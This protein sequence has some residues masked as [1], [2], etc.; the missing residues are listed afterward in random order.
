MA[1]LAYLG[2]LLIFKKMNPKISLFRIFLILT[3][4]AFSAFLG[5][6]LFYL[7]FE[8]QAQGNLWKNIFQGPRGLTFYGALGAGLPIFYLSCLFFL[9][10]ICRKRI[11]D[12]AA[13]ATAMAWVFMKVGCL[14]VGC[15]WGKVNLGFWSIVFDH[16]GS[17]M[18]FL[19]VPVYPVQVIDIAWGILAFAFLGNMFTRR[20]IA[21]GKLLPTYLAIYAICRFLTEFLRGDSG[22]GENI[23][24]IF[25]T[26]QLISIAMLLALAICFFAGSFPKKYL[27]SASAIFILFSFSACHYPQPPSSAQFLWVDH[28]HVDF[29]VYASRSTKPRKNAIFIAADENIQIYFAGDFAKQNGRAKNIEELAWWASA[30]LMSE[31][32]AKILR[33][34]PEKLRYASLAESLEYME[35]LGEPFD[36][37][38][39][40]H[41][42]PNH[43]SAGGR[44]YFL[45]HREL[46]A[47]KGKFSYLNLV[48]LQSCFGTT[49]ARDFLV[50]GA[51]QVIA[52]DGFNRSFFYFYF[53]LERI[54]IDEPIVAFEW[55]SARINYLI[56]GN[57]LANELLSTMGVTTEDY[58]KEI[59]NPQWF[60]R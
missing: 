16:P 23:L 37:Y 20:S 34:P 60:T 52:F 35:S 7:V 49:L 40:T 42:L 32:Y 28:S 31:N 38:L 54:R 51:N 25:S 44:G 43:L 9:N 26:S 58:L 6:R 5:A 48:F 56:R 24:W 41:G 50:A 29:E 15:C 46:L 21:S 55:V 53:F 30:P 3:I 11:F 22:R 33:I 1:I 39:L 59:S 17:V 8:S 18:P 14:C 36:L 57:F 13:L 19:G 27:Q 45:S 4:T 10:K 2:A 12:S 47:W